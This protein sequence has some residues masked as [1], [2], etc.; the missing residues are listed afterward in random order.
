[1]QVRDVMTKGAECVT[2]SASLQEAASKM[3]TLD[4]GPLPVCEDDYLVGMITDRDI[5]VRATAEALPPR[6][7]Q[8]RDVM[9]P[10][11]VY[12]FEDQD[13]EE[14]ARLM[15]ENQIRR[16]VVLDRDKRLVGI[17]SLGDLALE[18]GDEKLA[19]QTLEKVSQP[20]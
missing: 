20:V 6:L 2:P 4:I 8:V 3:K 5:T 11:V 16:L 1:M 9:T 7:G 17:V 13:V 15:K 14:A 18:T 10:D 19:G 12:C